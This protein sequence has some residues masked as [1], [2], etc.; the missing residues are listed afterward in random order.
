MHTVL[1]RVGISWALSMELLRQFELSRVPLFSFSQDVL[2]SEDEAR[3]TSPSFF[4]SF[5]QSLASVH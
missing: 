2:S 1:I 3:T 4:H 5:G